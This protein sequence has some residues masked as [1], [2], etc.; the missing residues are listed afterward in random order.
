MIIDDSLIP[1]T[2]DASDIGTSLRYW[3]DV[4]VQRYYVDNNACYIAS[5]GGMG[6]E[7]MMFTDT[8]TGTKTLAELAEP[9][10]ISHSL[11]DGAPTDAQIDAA[12]GTTPAAVGSGWRTTI[13]DSDGSAL[14]Y[15]IISDGTNWQYTALTIAL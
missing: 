7:D 5:T 15:I 2:T 10:V 1:S 4:Y 11:T 9:S 14:M 3:K 8:N 13:L 12:T 6:A